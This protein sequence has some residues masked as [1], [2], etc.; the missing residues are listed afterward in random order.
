MNL[1][2]ALL[3]VA[4]IFGDGPAEISF[5]E[6]VVSIESSFGRTSKNA[7]RITREAFTE[8]TTK[9]TPKF[10]RDLQRVYKATGVNIKKT[11]LKE[12]KRN[13][14]LNTIV[15]RLYLRT[16]PTPIPSSVADQAEYWLKY[17]NRGGVYQ[18]LSSKEDVLNIFITHARHLR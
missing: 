1:P 11:T 7:F 16:V 18:T 17:Y 12:V 10:N 2:T 9:D 13:I 15:A 6:N 4:A 3:L 14:L 8:V 5:M